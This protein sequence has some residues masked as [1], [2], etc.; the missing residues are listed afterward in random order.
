MTTETMTIHRGLSELKILDSRTMTAINGGVFCLP[1]KRSNEKLNGIPVE[2]YK[3]V[4]V[5]SYDKATDL[6]KRR[7]AIK[8]A[9][10]LSNACTKVEIGGAEYTVAEAIEMK[11][12]G[13]EFKK[14]L[15]NIM[16]KQYRDAQA[17]ILTQN[18]KDLEDRTEKYIVGLFGSGEKKTATEEIEKAKKAFIAA[19]EYELVDPLGI[20]AKIETLEEEI[21]NFMAEV[22]GALSTSNAVT[23]I[24]IEY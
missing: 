13:V 16:K 21:S 23:Q 12:H 17:K 11:N 8:R 18:G 3:K 20:L 6:I 15:L 9:I 2:E 22:D 10:V 7:E 5:G 19:N 14:Q 4:M 24:T 1:N